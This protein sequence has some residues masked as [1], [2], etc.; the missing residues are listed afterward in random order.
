MCH[1]GVGLGGGMDNCVKF[2]QTRS[3]HRVVF[4][5]DESIIMTDKSG[6]EIHLDTTGSNINITS[7]ETMMLNCKN[8]NDKDTSND[9]N[10]ITNKISLWKFRWYIMRKD[11]NL[12]ELVKK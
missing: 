6:S 1:G 12:I 8:M 3:G 7:P 9:V 4:T 5:E 11:P 10:L 2:I